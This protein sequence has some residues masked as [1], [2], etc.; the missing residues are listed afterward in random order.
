MKR[1]NAHLIPKKGQR[2]L[3]PVTKL[4]IAPTGEIKTLVGKD[5]RYWKRRLKDGDV[6][7]EEIPKVIRQKKP[8]RSDKGD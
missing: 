1:L 3:D 7:I 2:V 6:T 8:V 5:G 4:P